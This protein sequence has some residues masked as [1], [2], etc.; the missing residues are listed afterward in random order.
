MAFVKAPDLGTRSIGSNA[1]ELDTWLR[2]MQWIG[3]PFNWSLIHSISLSLSP[4]MDMEVTRS[5][6]WSILHF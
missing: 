2:A 3:R 4:H 6:I 5:V 1:H